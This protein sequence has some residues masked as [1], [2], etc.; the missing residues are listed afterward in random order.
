MARDVRLDILTNIEN[1]NYCGKLFLDENQSLPQN[2]SRGK[3]LVEQQ[4]FYARDQMLESLEL[5]QL[6]FVEI[7]SSMIYK[8]TQTIFDYSEWYVSKSQPPTPIPQ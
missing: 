1:F 7:S 4:G 2:K 6:Y 8:S 3:E 5:P